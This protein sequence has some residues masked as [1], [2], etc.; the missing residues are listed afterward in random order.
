M[1][2]FKTLFAVLVLYRHNMQVLHWNATGKQFDR[3]H[4]ICDEY[5][6]KLGECIDSIAEKLIMCGERP[7]SYEEVLTQVKEDEKEFVM[8]T[9]D[10]QYCF[11]CAFSAINDMFETLI[12]LYNEVLTTVELPTGMKSSLESELEWFEL[13]KCYKNEKRLAEPEDCCE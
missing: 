6:E 13:E 2:C 1:N 11:A 10:V 5:T 8:L 9:T 7:L 3:V 4:K 12:K